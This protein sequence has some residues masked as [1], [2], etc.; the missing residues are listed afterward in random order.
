M[1][2]KG[3][4]ALIGAFVAM[5]GAAQ[6]RAAD[7]TSAAD[8]QAAAEAAAPAADVSA[9]EDAE[10]LRRRIQ[11][12]E[13]EIARLKT[14]SAGVAD[15]QKRLAALEAELGRLKQERTGGV[16]ASETRSVNGL[17]PSASR[18]YL[19]KRGLA[20]GGYGSALYQRFTAHR[21]NDTDANVPDRA[22]LTEAFV[23]VGYRFDDR[24]LFNSSFGVEHALV[25]D[26]SDGDATVEFA[27]VDFRQKKQLG[28]R[29]GLMLL[30]VGLVNERH[31]P[32]DYLG[33]MRPFVEQRIV[34]STWRGVGAGAYGEAGAVEWRGYV[35]E[36][37]DAAGFTPVEGIAG[38]RQQGS[39]SLAEDMALTARVDW[40]PLRGKGIGDLLVGASGFAGRTG[41]QQPGFPG[42]RLTLWD[43]HAEYRWRGFQARA[44]YASGILGQAGEIS[45]AIDPAGLTA[46]GERSDGLY[47]E[48]GYDVL[49]TWPKSKQDLIVFCRFENL[50]TQE[51]VASGLP[52][53][54]LADLTVKTCGVQY[55]PIPQVVIKADATNFSDPGELSV[56]QVNLGLGWNF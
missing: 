23:Y 10:A 41:Q 6:A 36:S 34:P 50:N 27:Y 46:I 22:D 44:L 5:L 20:L 55:A 54:S 42:G 12:L 11:A 17:S 26:G 37:L 43:A 53:D 14:E 1:R 13:E 24:L 52:T 15:I 28:W 19:T 25:E 29:G 16:A 40:R 2:I 49:S 4:G 47:L 9:A 45:L 7:G 30:P 39:N 3:A 38:G 32:A 8:P 35:V 31:E 33:T 51:E 48:I 56:D 18:V 21:D